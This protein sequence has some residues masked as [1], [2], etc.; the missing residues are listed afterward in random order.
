MRHRLPFGM[1]ALALTVST[2]A[3]AAPPADA[4]IGN[5]ISVSVDGK[6]I[7]YYFNANGSASMATS[8]GDA[9][10][11]TWSKKGAQLCVA[12]QAANEERCATLPSD[13]VAAG[14]SFS[15]TDSK[16]AERVAKLLEGKVPF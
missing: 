13:D 11:G 6:E 9:D 1:I 14:Q 12:W 16:G 15:Y 2:S 10:V 5:T 4:A 7:R 3:V 8:A